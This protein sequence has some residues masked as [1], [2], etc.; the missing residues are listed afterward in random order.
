MSCLLFW[1][2]GGR[3]SDSDMENEANAGE[4]KKDGGKIK[5]KNMWRTRKMKGLQKKAKTKDVERA[6]ESQARQ[7][8][9]AGEKQSD[10]P[11]VPAGLGSGSLDPLSSVML[12]NISSPLHDDLQI[13]AEAEYEA[14]KPLMCPAPD[15]KDADSNQPLENERLEKAAAEAEAEAIQEL[16]NIH[17]DETEETVEKHLGDETTE[18]TL[19]EAEVEAVKDLM[20]LFIDKI[21]A[22]L[23]GREVMNVIDTEPEAPTLT[24]QTYLDEVDTPNDHPLVEEE[25]FEVLDTDDYLETETENLGD[26]MTEPTL[27]EAEVEAVKDPMLLFIDKIEADLLGCE[28][29]NVIDPEPE[30]PTLTMQT[31]LDEVDTPNDHPLLEEEI[32]E[33]LDTDDH[34]ETETEN[35]AG[36]EMTEAILTEAE[37]EAVKRLMLLYIDKIEAESLGYDV[38]SAADEVETHNMQT[39]LDET[40]PSNDQALDVERK[41]DDEADWSTIKGLMAD[42]PHGVQ[43]TVDQ[44]LGNAVEMTVD[45]ETIKSGAD[46]V[47][48]LEGNINQTAEIGTLKTDTPENETKKDKQK[49]KTRRGTRGKGRKINYKKAQQKEKVI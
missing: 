31:F 43:R 49:K 25:I 20:L 5:R 16:M 17:L 11:H 28:V 19:T 18:P 3:T 1:C 14:L 35:L 15:E 46:I 23:L 41:S 40:D 29:M 9:A 7:Q 6:E 26:E 21:E 12:E 33:V 13:E 10:A 45:P 8:P 44:S 30:A 39:H 42:L 24:M 38:M 27:T 32:F 4:V 47:D 36:D 34:L 48:H 22:D 37:V 2:C